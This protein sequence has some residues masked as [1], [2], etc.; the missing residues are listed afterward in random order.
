M[1]WTEKQAESYISGKSFDEVEAMG[2][3]SQPE[4]SD[5]TTSTEVNVEAP[6][7]ETTTAETSSDE[8]VKEETSTSPVTEENP[9]KVEAVNEDK[10][11]VPTQQDKIA[12]SF[13]KEKAKRREAQAKLNEKLKEI[14]EL[15]ERL[16]KFE[17]LTLEDFKGDNNSYNDY[18]FDQKWNTKMVERLQKEYDEG[19]ETLRREENTELAQER[20]ENCFPDVNEQNRYKMMVADAETN[21]G[22]KHPEY[23]YNKFSEFLMSEEDGT[24]LSY[25]QDSDNSPKLIRHFIMKPEVVDRIMKLRNPYNKV[26][27]LK[28]LENRMLQYERTKA[29]KAKITAPVKK[30]LPDTGKIVQNSNSLNTGLT[31]DKPMTEAEAIRYFQSKGRI[32]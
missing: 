29:T 32:R 1:A 23:G 26:Y 9:E 16:K 24:V 18:R 5:E 7:A 19:S 25:L 12:H 11:K 20:L 4:Q 14:E 13:A 6:G 30:E 10:K 17:G 31:L 21:F 2:G 15:K 8:P 22:M 27:E 28:Q 3:T